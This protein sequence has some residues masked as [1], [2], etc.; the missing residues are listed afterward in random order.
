MD[1]LTADDDLDPRDAIARLEARIE[2]LEDKI[3]NCR[4]YEAAAKFAI[5]IGA[6]LLVALVFRLIRFDQLL[7]LFAIAAGLGG[8]VLLGSNGSTR[9]QA[10]DQ[11]AQAE[12]ERA[13]LIGAIN[14]RV[15]RGEETM[16]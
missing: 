7:F 3:E 5:A 11:L 6:L 14:L 15:V 1:D 13:S 12:A 16:H 4:K 2:A 10:A 8:F 9:N